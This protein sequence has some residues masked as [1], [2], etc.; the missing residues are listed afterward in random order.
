[1]RFIFDCFYI[2]IFSFKQYRTK[3]FHSFHTMT[4]R[5]KLSMINSSVYFSNILD[6][7]RAMIAVPYSQEFPNISQQNNFCPKPGKWEIL[8]VVIIYQFLFCF[9]LFIYLL[10]IIPGFI[11]LSIILGFISLSI[12]IL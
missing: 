2:F 10:L 12:I 3:I 1:M 9:C 4:V 6:L 7:N 8:N 11:L 5:R